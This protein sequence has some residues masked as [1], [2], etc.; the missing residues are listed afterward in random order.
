MRMISNKKISIIVPVYNTE[1]YLSRC[2][3][4]LIRQTYQNLEIIFVDDASPDKSAEI[5]QNYMD[6]DKRL[7]YIKHEKNRGLF[8]ARVTGSKL[9][10]GD[11]IAFVD[12]DDYVSMDFYHQLVSRAEE[13]HADIVIGKTV[14]VKK[15]NRYYERNL[16]NS[17]FQFEKL[18]SSEKIRAEFFGQKGYCYSWHT[19]WNKL[20]TKKLWDSCLPYFERI[21]EHVIMTEDIAFSSLLFYNA[22]CVSKIN[23]EA[24]FYCENMA[25]STNADKISFSRYE[26]NVRDMQIVFD[27]VDAYLTEQNCSEQIKKDFQEFR[28]YYS[29]MWRELGEVTFL[30]EEKKKVEKMMENFLP[31]YRE[32]LTQDD[33]FFASIE[34]KWNNG[35]EYLKEKIFNEKVEYISFD[36]FDTVVMR[37]VYYPEDIFLLLDQDFSKMCSS[38][39]NFSILRIGAEQEARRS[40]AERNRAYQDVTIDEIYQ[41]LTTQYN[42]PENIAERMCEKEKALEIELCVR[43]NAA[44]ELYDMAL[45]SGKKII[46][47]SDMYLDRSTIECILHKNGF[48]KYERLFLSSEERVTKNSGKLYEHVLSTLHVDGNQVLHIGDTWQNDIINAEKYG[49]K[50]IFFPKYREVF[51]NKI[52]GVTTNQCGTIAYRAAGR[53][54]NEKKL[55]ASLGYRSMLAVVAM[56]YFDNP[57]RSFHEESDFN[58][59]PFFIGYYAVGMHLVGLTKWIQQ[60]VT[61]HQYKTI[62]FMSRDGYL[63][64]HAY[65]IV[66]EYNDK[67]PDGKYI[68]S[69]RKAVLPAMLKS[70]LDFYDLPIEYRNHSPKTI[71]KLLSFCTRNYEETTLK[72][73]GI[74]LNKTFDSIEEFRQFI[75]YYLNYLYDSNKHQKALQKVQQYYNEELSDGSCTFD[76]GYS[77]RI[78]A[79]VSYAVGT[80]VDVMFVHSDDKRAVQLSMK[81]QFNIYSFY[82]FTPNVTGVF[83]EHI[84]SEPEPSCIGFEEKNGEILPVFDDEKKQY[85]DH[86]IVSLLQKGALC[87]VR[88][89]YEYFG[90]YQK[91]LSFKPQEV[92][93]PYEAYLQYAK[94]I[95]I[96]IWNASYFE[97]KVY[98]ARNRIRIYDFIKNEALNYSLT[99]DGNMITDRST[100]LEHFLLGKSRYTKALVFFCLDKNIFKEKLKGKLYCYPRLFRICKKVYRMLRR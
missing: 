52:G 11:Y 78:Q 67:L 23:S 53:I 74:L 22:Q 48:V 82:D 26:K 46:F 54:Q 45:L 65:Q 100:V 41:Y 20:Y 66:K 73:N 93:L 94:D 38:N 97:D 9:A 16:H 27:F 96:R 2:I 75:R 14:F 71:L 21:K 44:K 57:Y 90:G 62:H 39:T 79:A 99:T 1:K 35:L 69:S 36:I 55:L 10:T 5:I 77:G 40:V 89:F 49:L 98:G 86:F 19:I 34:T 18:S 68:Y 31:T 6:A 51:E 88:D 17:V 80:G 4:S 47:T 59:D 81:D 43:R 70:K 58:A 32:Y 76:L 83:R 95:D 29:R 37:P 13:Q 85:Q 24:Y 56:H 92:S 12:S 25:A 50:T 60:V 64:L 33:H 84:F 72:E 15:D 63:P 7:R 8:Q 42:I 87:F 30:R 61:E 91:V 28:K 3:E